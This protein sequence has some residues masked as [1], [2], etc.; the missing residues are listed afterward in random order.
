MELAMGYQG[1]EGAFLAFVRGYGLDLDEMA[2]HV[3]ESCESEDWQRAEMAYARR[4]GSAAGLSEREWCA[5]NVLKT[6]WRRA[7]PA[8]SGLWQG[9]EQAVKA[10]LSGK[11][12][13]C[14]AGRL[15]FR[16]ISGYLVAMLPS[17]RFVCY[18]AA[19]LTPRGGLFEYY[20]QIQTTRRWDF[21][22]S[23][24]GKVTENVTQA[25]ARDIL[26]ESM[27]LAE[28]KGYRIVLSVHDELITE[29]PDSPEF[30]AEKLSGIMTTAP[31]WAE[32]LPLSA[33]GFE[34]YRYRKD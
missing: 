13:S 33:A 3:S 17:G 7:H 8:I 16:L 32:D 25:T 9:I 29:T 20:G 10:V 14:I 11:M 19:R 4:S 28:E 27:P 34:A 5:C 15:T 22:R 30:S 12:A 26:A 24:S 2:G 1:G 18:P 31:A 6:L 21:I 23:Y